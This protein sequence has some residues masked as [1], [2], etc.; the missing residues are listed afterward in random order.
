MCELSI[1]VP[2]Y[3]NEKYL[4]HTM[5]ALLTQKDIS[6][7]I[8]LIDDGSID[9][10]A[11]LCDELCSQYSVVKAVHIKNGGPGRA[12]N[13]GIDKAEGTYIGFCDADDIPMDNMYGILVD[14]MR[15]VFC[16][17]CMCDIYSER[18]KRNFGFP[19]KGDRLFDQKETKT[20][21]MASMLGNHSDDDRESPVWGSS[22]RGIYKKEILDRWAVRFPEDIRFAEDL[23]FNI[24]YLAHCN[25]SYVLDRAMYRYTFNQ[26]SLMNSYV[27]Y[28]DR[29]FQER[30]ALIEYLSAVIVDIDTSCELQKRMRISE[31][32]YFHECV[33]NAARAI[34]EKGYKY[35]CDEIKKIV[36]HSEVQE[37]FE[38]LK[39]TGKKKKLL[40]TLIQKKCA[41]VLT[42][43]YALRLH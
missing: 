33:G 15:D 16:D 42:V 41:W 30:L 2:V 21:L 10:S 31:R 26:E 19:W 29:M 36:N 22:V 32:C 37:A 5:K 38:T 3:N 6:Y 9:N 13:I 34:P 12:R 14:K 27:R 25:R 7:E 28:N 23:V 1:I 40:Y 11:R 18:D 35:A 43:Y 20:A 39:V 17:Y 8:I 24:R 4:N